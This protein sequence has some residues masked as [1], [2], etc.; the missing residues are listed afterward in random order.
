LLTTYA[1][2]RVGQTVEVRIEAEEG[3]RVRP[4]RSVEV[5]V[6]TDSGLYQQRGPETSTIV[7]P[8]E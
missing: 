7:V 8:L 6:V 1:A 5:V 2:E 4:E 3:Q